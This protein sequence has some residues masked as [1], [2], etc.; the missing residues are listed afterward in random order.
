MR[1]NL[2]CFGGK[3][4]EIYTKYL[5]LNIYI[6]TLTAKTKQTKGIIYTIY[7][8][9]IQYIH[10]C[11]NTERGEYSIL[12]NNGCLFTYTLHTFIFCTCERNIKALNGYGITDNRNSI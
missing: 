3:T 11:T 7:I 5:H 8:Q 2:E 12:R 10:I 4:K 6:Y 1:S 9:Y